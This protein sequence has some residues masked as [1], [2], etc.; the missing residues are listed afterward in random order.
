[1]MRVDVAPP[2][3]AHDTVSFSWTQSEPNPYQEFNEFF[4][5][6]ENVALKDFSSTLLLEIFLGLQFGVWRLEDH[7]V[8]VVL[9]HPF[10]ASSIAFWQAYHQADSV[11]VRPTFEDSHT[12]PFTPWASDPPSIIDART[13]AVFFG[14]GKD[15]LLT[16]CLLS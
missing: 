8:E 9:P 7:P 6:Y 2:L 11:T 5:R 15:S 3:I 4:F 1:M 14:G 12:T 13:A 10:P 16:T